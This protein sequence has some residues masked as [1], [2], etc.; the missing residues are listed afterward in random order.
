MT[1]SAK[2]EQ[3]MQSIRHIYYGPVSLFRPV[4]KMAL[5]VDQAIGWSKIAGGR[6][7]IAK[8]PFQLGPSLRAA[9][10]V[11]AVERGLYSVAQV[12]DDVGQGR[13]KWDRVCNGRV[14]CLEPFARCFEHGRFRT[15][16]KKTASASHLKAHV[17][18]SNQLAAYLAQEAKPKLSGRLVSVRKLFP[19]LLSGGDVYKRTA[20]KREKA[21][22]QRRI[23]PAEHYHIGTPASCCAHPALA[24][25]QRGAA[26]SC[27]PRP[28]IEAEPEQRHRNQRE[29]QPLLKALELHG[30]LHG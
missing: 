18:E 11:G 24:P 21:R 29:R 2:L 28:S 12:R 3:P 30:S 17:A 7:S 6:S 5:R 23:D 9:A 27:H 26:M 16:G 1:R 10:K 15:A 22:A 13:G 25:L 14:Q 19:P 4:D 20:R 8:G